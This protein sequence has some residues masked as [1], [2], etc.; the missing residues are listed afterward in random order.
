MV[1]LAVACRPARVSATPVRRARTSGTRV[2][3]SASPS[4]A[5]LASST[6]TVSFRPRP[7]LSCIAVR[8]ATRRCCRVRGDT[9]SPSALEASTDTAETAP[10]ET[11]SLI[12]QVLAGVTVSLAMVPESLA[13]TFVAGVSPIVGLHAAALMGLSTACLGAQPGVISG[14]AGATAVVFAPLV[15]THG[16]EYLFVAVFLA[17]A[18]QLACGAARLGKLIR[19]GRCFFIP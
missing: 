18:I 10:A 16:A 15:K 5:Y 11:S 3:A 12:G 6:A 13:F 14:A 9:V 1:T 8:T 2:V 7:G 19:L 17:G 4:C